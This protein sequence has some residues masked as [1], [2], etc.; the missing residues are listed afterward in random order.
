MKIKIN[1][2]HSET[3]FPHMIMGKPKDGMYEESLENIKK[4]FQGNLPIFNLS[5]VKWAQLVESSKDEIGYGTWGHIAAVELDVAEA[6]MRYSFI[7]IF[8]FYPEV[9]SIQQKITEIVSTFDYHNNSFAWNIG[10]L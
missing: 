2:I 3:M 4:L 7:I 1:K 10:D 8:N 9:E 6:D 5:I